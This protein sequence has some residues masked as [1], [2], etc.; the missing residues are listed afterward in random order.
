MRIGDGDD[1]RTRDEGHEGR[2]EKKSND[3]GA[4]EMES[5]SVCE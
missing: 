2:E 4:G 5:R 3:V 1:G